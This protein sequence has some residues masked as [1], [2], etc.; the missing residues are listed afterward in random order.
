VEMSY[1]YLTRKKKTT[2]WEAGDDSGKP[3]VSW[4]SFELEH[5]IGFGDIDD[6]LGWRVDPD[7]Q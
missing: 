6:V 4:T 3:S 5:P 1:N 7:G 2:T